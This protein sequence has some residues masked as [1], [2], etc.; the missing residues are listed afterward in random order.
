MSNCARICVPG[1]T[2]S[3]HMS[4]TA[5]DLSSCWSLTRFFS[6]LGRKN[7]TD[8]SQISKVLPHFLLEATGKT[9]DV[10]TSDFRKFSVTEVTVSVLSFHIHSL[11]F[12]LF[13]SWGNCQCG[14]VRRSQKQ[15][16][17]GA[18]FDSTN[19]YLLQIQIRK[20]RPEMKTSLAMLMC[21]LE[22]TAERSYWLKNTAETTLIMGPAMAEA[23]RG[24]LTVSM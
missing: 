23:R 8:E 19:I 22:S 11:F 7:K 18:F 13:V 3:D 2:T 12:C 9:R 16:L 24:K 5:S 20:H 14:S 17:I 1:S 10:T 21:H 4:W 15:N 6:N